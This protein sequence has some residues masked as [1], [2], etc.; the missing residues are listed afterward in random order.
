MLFEPNNT[1]QHLIHYLTTKRGFYVSAKYEQ[2]I[3]EYDAAKALYDAHD[4]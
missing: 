1:D 3:K 2:R 4:Y